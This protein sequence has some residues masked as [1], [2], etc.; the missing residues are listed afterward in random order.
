MIIYAENWLIGVVAILM[1]SD[2]IFFQTTKILKSLGYNNERAAYFALTSV[3][4]FVCVL[5][6]GVFPCVFIILGSIN[7]NPLLMSPVA[8][9]TLF[10]YLI[11]LTI[12]NIWLIRSACVSF[13]KSRIARKEAEHKKLNG[14]LKNGL[15]DVENPYRNHIDIPTFNQR[16]DLSNRTDSSQISYV[17]N[18]LETYKADLGLYNISKENNNVKSI[19]NSNVY[20]KGHKKHKSMK[21]I[22]L[23]T[24]LVTIPE[25][26]ESHSSV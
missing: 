16:L 4:L 7:Q 19:P 17:K 12:V 13:R 5:T 9:A 14:T 2:V 22:M 8:L 20:G 15:A 24:P 10:L 25:D 21:K 1:D 18:D 26:S 3:G 11:F 6:R 23:K